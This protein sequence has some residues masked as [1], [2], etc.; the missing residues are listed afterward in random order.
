MTSQY[1]R[2]EYNGWT[3]AIFGG[4]EEELLMPTNSRTFEVGFQSPNTNSG[5]I[6]VRVKITPN[7]ALS[8]AIVLI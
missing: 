2:I 8:R 6:N 4:Y 7:G 3:V 1:L 5:E